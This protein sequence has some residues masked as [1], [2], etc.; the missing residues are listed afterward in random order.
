MEHSER[1]RR[2][3]VFSHRDRGSPGGKL[4]G[5]MRIKGEAV[6]NLE[7]HRRERK[8]AGKKQGRNGGTYLNDVWRDGCVVVVPVFDVALEV[9]VEVLE[10]EVE[11][12][13]DVHDVKESVGLHA[14]RLESEGRGPEEEK[15]K[16]RQK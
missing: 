6:G 13:V 8:D 15:R 7:K 16:A 4:C 11:L 14:S 2:K 1:Q 3:G 12:L 5:G 10:D 9:D